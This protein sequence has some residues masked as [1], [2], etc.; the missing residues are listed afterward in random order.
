MVPKIQKLT[1]TEMNADRPYLKP[2]ARVWWV[3]PFTGIVMNGS[4]I[5]ESKDKPKEWYVRAD[6]KVVY[7]IPILML[8]IPE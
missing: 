2:G 7:L 4:I 8:K 1:Y 3:D 5:N 6:D